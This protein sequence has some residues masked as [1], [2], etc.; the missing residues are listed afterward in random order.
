M[1]ITLYRED[2]TPTFLGLRGEFVKLS[3]FRADIFR[4]FYSAEKITF[5]DG[6]VPFVLK[7]RRLSE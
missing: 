1:D 6:S 7:D 5:M 2:L 4:T 3:Y